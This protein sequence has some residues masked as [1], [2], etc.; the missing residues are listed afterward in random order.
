MRMLSFV[1]KQGAAHACY[2]SAAPRAC[3]VY[4]Q[5]SMH[6]RHGTLQNGA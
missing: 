4:V 6:M 2:R 5:E 1:R 3:I